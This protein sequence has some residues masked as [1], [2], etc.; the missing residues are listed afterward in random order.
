MSIDVFSFSG[1]RE[2]DDVS[3]VADVIDGGEGLNEG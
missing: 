1:T 3:F 2:L